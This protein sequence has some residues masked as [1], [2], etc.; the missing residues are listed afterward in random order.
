MGPAV[1]DIKMDITDILA[2]LDALLRYT[3][4]SRERFELANL[5]DLSVANSI[6]DRLCTI[7]EQVVTL[8]T[9]KNAYLNPDIS[10]TDIQLI[11]FNNIGLVDRLA[12]DI[13]GRIRT[14][15]NQ[16]LGNDQ[17]L[18]LAGIYDGVMSV[19]QPTTARTHPILAVFPSYEVGIG[20]GV[21]IGLVALEN[22]E[23]DCSSLSNLLCGF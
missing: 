15:A 10:Y 3:D 13:I 1:L 17:R 14:E 7:R 12:S 2:K 4:T 18:L 20:R 19:M 11:N 16:P 22:G 6:N 23:F 5:D 21:E 9:R 8:V